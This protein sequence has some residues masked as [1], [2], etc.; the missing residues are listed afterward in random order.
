MA[1]QP[2]PPI[3]L[4]LP[5]ALLL[6]AVAIA[7][8]I[9]RHHWERHYYKICFALAGFVCGYY[10]FVRRDPQRVTHALFEYFSFLV[11]VG[12]FF[13]VAG[14][15]HL[16]PRSPGRPLANAL[17]LLLGGLLASAIGTIGASM[18]LIRPWIEMNKT[19]FSGFHLAFFIFI[20]SNLG[21]LLLPVGP[22][23][24]LGYQN[25]VPFF[26]PLARLW[27]HW[28]FVSA[29]LLAIFFILDSLKWARSIDRAAEM[30]VEKWRVFGKR[31]L[32]FLAILIVALI[33]LPSPA[34]EMVMIAAAIASYFVSPRHVHQAN[35][36]TFRP[37]QEVAALFLAIFGTMLP[38]LDYMQLHAA[39][40]GV[41]TG[42]QFFWST[43]MLSALLDNAPTY[44]TFS[45]VALGLHGFEANNAKDVA[46]FIAGNDHLF[47]AISLGATLFGA[48]T[49]IG[50]GPNLLVRAIAQN[51]NLPTPSFIA[52]SLKYAAP[53][54]LPIFALLSILF[55]RN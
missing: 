21:G 42:R 13:I 20:V 47:I 53:I 55:L 50:N 49:Y 3:W 6:L 1:T 12:A 46:T 36:F 15:I 32:I 30:P 35:A 2:A 25:G 22:P 7:P 45:A 34:R 9:L 4:L 48:L 51:V 31:N 16:R 52:F 44:L 26:W 38:V 29:L 14:G 28:L 40:I 5:F 19:R 41:K 39:D 17:F 37:L 18:V 23:L 27:P 54:L 43:G 33:V 8:L 24:F 10:L 11:V